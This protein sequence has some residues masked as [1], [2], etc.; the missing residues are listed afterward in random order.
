MPWLK[1]GGKRTVGFWERI[2][3]NQKLARSYPHDAQMWSIHR[4]RA[5]RLP[6]RYDPKAKKLVFLN[7]RSLYTASGAAIGDAL[8]LQRL[9]QR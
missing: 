5:I 1:W 4:R 8:E 2:A 3:G 7:Q 9:F 6:I